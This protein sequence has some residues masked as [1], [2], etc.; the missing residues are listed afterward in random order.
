M[1]VYGLRINYDGDFTDLPVIQ[2]GPYKV[3][4]VRDYAVIPIGLIGPFIRA[5]EQA[6][7]FLV[8]DPRPVVDK[9]PEFIDLEQGIAA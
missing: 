7:Q 5:K 3:I 9:R 8:I 4:A 1:M 6:A 2:A